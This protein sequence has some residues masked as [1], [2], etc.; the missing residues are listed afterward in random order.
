MALG[1]YTRGGS[2]SRRARRRCRR[3]AGAADWRQTACLRRP[4]GRPLLTRAPLCPRFQTSF[5]WKCRQCSRRYLSLPVGLQH[6]QSVHPQFSSA[7]AGLVRVCRII[8]QPADSGAV[9]TRSSSGAVTPADRDRPGADEPGLEAG[10]SRDSEG[11]MLFNKANLLKRLPSGSERCVLCRKVFTGHL[12]ACGHLRLHDQ[13]Q[14]EAYLGQKVQ[15][16]RKRRP[17]DL[18]TE[19]EEYELDG[20]NAETPPDEDGPDE[21]GPPVLEPVSD[22]EIESVPESSDD[23]IGEPTKDTAA[24]PP[25]SV[26]SRGFPVQMVAADR[27]RRRHFVHALPSGEHV[28]TLCD[29]K[30]PR[31]PAARAHLARH[32]RAEVARYVALHAVDGLV[33][34][35]ATI[36]IRPERETE[37]AEPLEA[38][39]VEEAEA[40]QEV[41]KMEEAETVDEDE[42]VEDAEGAEEGEEQEGEEEEMDAEAEAETASVDTD[43]AAGAK[44]L[45]SCK[46]WSPGRSKRSSAAEETDEDAEEEE[47]GEGEEEDDTEQDNAPLKQELDGEMVDKWE[48]IRRKGSRLRC[49]VC[50]KTFMKNGYAEVHLRTEHTFREIRDFVRNWRLKGVRVPPR[51][52]EA[53]DDEE[54]DDEEPEEAPP[55]LS[56][57]LTSLS[58]PQ[59]KSQPKPLPATVAETKTNTDAR[60]VEQ[61]GVK[62]PAETAPVASPSKAVKRGPMVLNV[63]T[64]K[65][66]R[67]LPRGAPCP[68]GPNTKILKISRSDLLQKRKD[69]VRICLVCDQQLESHPA[70][71]EHMRQH[72]DADIRNFIKTRG[73]EFLP[74][75]EQRQKQRTLV[76]RVSAETSSAVTSPVTPVT[77]QLVRSLSVGGTKKAS[78]RPPVLSPS[79]AG[80]SPKPT[81]S[82]PAAAAPAPAPAPAPVKAPVTAAGATAAPAAVPTSAPAPARAP[83]AAAPAPAPAAASAAKPAAETPSPKPKPPT[84]VESPDEEPLHRDEA[85]CEF[86]LFDKAQL[87]K[88]QPDGTKCLL[89]TRVFAKHSSA[90]GHLSHHGAAEVQAWR[91]RMRRKAS[92]LLK[93]A[94]RPRAYSGAE[95]EKAANTAPTDGSEPQ[96]ESE[97]ETDEKVA[98]KETKKDKSETIAENDQPEAKKARGNN[99]AEKTE[100]LEGSKAVR[101]TRRKD[102]APVK[103]PRGDTASTEKDTKKSEQS[104]PVQVVK[105][106]P[107]SPVEVAEVEKPRPSPK[108]FQVIGTRATG[109]LVKITETISAKQAKALLEKA[110]TSDKDVSKPAKTAASAPSTPKATASSAK[111]TT[112]KP[113]PAKT[114][115]KTPTPAK[116]P[117]T[118]TQP[119]PPV[120]AVKPIQPVTMAA[121]RAAVPAGVTVVTPV[122]GPVPPRGAVPVRGAQL[123]KL[124]QAVKLALLQSADGTIQTAGG[125]TIMRLAPGVKLPITAANLPRVLRP[126]A[127]KAAAA[128]GV[129]PGG[130]AET[131]AEGGTAAA[132]AVGVTPMVLQ[133]PLAGAVTSPGSAPRP[134]P[135]PLLRA[136]LLQTMTRTGGGS[137][138]VHVPAIKAPT[139]LPA[140]AVV[141]TVV[142]SGAGAAAKTDG[143]TVAK[144]AGIGAK[145]EARA[146]ADTKTVGK[147]TE[148]K[149][150]GKTVTKPGI[151]ARTEDR[152]DVNIKTGGKKVEAKTDGKTVTKTGIDTKKEARADVNIKTVG[153]KIEAKIDWKMVA[154]A[155]AEA[156]M[157]KQTNAKAD[158]KDSKVGEK[159]DGRTGEMPK[160][161]EKRPGEDAQRKKNAVAT[162]SEVR[163]GPESVAADDAKSTK[164]QSETKPSQVKSP[165][166][167]PGS[168]SEKRAEPAVRSSQRK[169]AAAV[170]EKDGK[171]RP[172][173]SAAATA[174]STASPKP[175]VVTKRAFIPEVA[176]KA[177][178][179]CSWT[180]ETS[181][182]SSPRAAAA[183][184]E[185]SGKDSPSATPPGEVPQTRARAEAAIAAR[186]RQTR[187]SSGATSASDRK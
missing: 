123:V 120:S 34:V 126:I 172:S 143:K 160:P 88:R 181:S 21:D 29:A 11:R 3:P 106:E 27:V 163:S 90:C 4:A 89:C 74:A 16:I 33:G 66:T 154:K 149:T 49:V 57:Q 162:E 156:R 2:G 171:D 95:A 147:K 167:P 38:V 63:P 52:G 28:C 91:N 121:V 79:A 20:A 96:T 62:R 180:P 132:T 144:A 19:P 60:P 142:P 18:Q 119:T 39:K 122:S 56:P 99:S 107:S 129:A 40:E 55:Q 109:R 136:P 100:K 92:A 69:G 24:K 161:A 17:A 127:P 7:R 182:K 165:A 185:S 166:A 26:E 93:L 32:S 97:M 176:A 77:T 169:A 8:R 73:R 22:A 104:A 80:E 78:D 168:D 111:P 155:Q 179:R 51:S 130:S 45:V 131:G 128:A 157:G 86:E 174:T 5:E 87:L 76:R 72:S 140:G 25:T 134:R 82:A 141:T 15:L 35:P 148:T 116:T 36:A 98:D 184:A 67:I 101:A 112:D 42:K 10:H 48:V 178:T 46:L 61:R 159:A 6:V 124:P 151:D 187:R 75:F 41:E 71:C 175:G 47:D 50:N 177:A 117:K 102:S 145:T 58:K 84:P 43:I 135:P 183:A 186:M 114:P 103:V 30:F 115:D 13:R 83:V 1:L 85:V 137:I 138:T 31:W 53:D 164:R 81:A 70:A 68:I 125:R 94:R 59:P 170:V 54:S 153:K 105:T 139:P 14:I 9:S 12:Q 110:A 37:A 173:A 64:V 108:T 146:D 133:P 158:G 113:T 65:T 118:P 150:D 23:T 152:A 44:L